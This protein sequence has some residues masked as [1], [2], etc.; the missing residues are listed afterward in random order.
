M[1]KE[2]QLLEK[3]LIELS[4]LAF[5]RDIVTF[6]DFLNLNELNILHRTP[7]DQFK[8]RFETYGGYELAERQ[9]VAFLPDAL[10]YDYEYPIQI[11]EVTP[12]SKRFAED[13][14]HRDYLGALMN[15]G[16]ERSKVG[17]IIVEDQKGLIFVKEELAEYIADNLTV[18]RHTNVNTSIGK[19]VKV[20]YEPR[21]EE[22]KGTVSS[23]RL[24]SVLALP[25]HF[26]EVRLLHRL[27]PEKSL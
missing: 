26:P 22:L 24:D 2:E 15:L 10:Y 13:L 6:S 27:K 12:S 20:D 4:N 3:R 11:I 8:A 18:V 23:I 7:K 14:T 17:D 21:F 25:I 1:N 5:S 19:G 9:M 16:I